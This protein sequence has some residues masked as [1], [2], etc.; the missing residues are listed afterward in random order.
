MNFETLTALSIFAF[1]SSA[2]PGPN[3]LMLL[4]SGANFGF[5]RTI[6]HMMGISV[7]F[8]VM[9]FA[10]G[11]GLVQ[12]FDRFPVIY[13]VLKVI[14]VIYMIW[15]AWKIANAAPVTK[16]ARPLAASLSDVKPRSPAAAAAVG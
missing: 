14:S 4:A 2:T 3:N 10:V 12:V 16:N 11:A 15:L 7:G 1:V 8:M 5:W 13:D 6:P 9:M